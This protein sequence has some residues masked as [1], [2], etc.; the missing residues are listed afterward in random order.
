MKIFN[1]IP[2]WLIPLLLWSQAQGQSDTIDCQAD[3]NYSISNVTFGAGNIG[4]LIDNDRSIQVSIGQPFAGQSGSTAQG[5]TLSNG[6]FGHYD[7]EPQP[8]IAKAS[9]GEFLDRIEVQWEVITDRVGPW[10]TGTETVIYR[11]GREIVTVPLKQKTYVDYNVFP[12]EFYTYEIATSNEYGESYTLP[13]VGF[14]NPNGRVTGKV[15]TRNGSPVADVKVTLSP[16]LGTTL[17]FDGTKSYAYFEN[18]QF[19]FNKYYTVEGWWRNVGVDKE[20]TLFVAND[21]GTTNPVIKISLDNQNRLTYFHDGNADGTGIT[22]VSKDGYNLTSLTREWHHFAAVFDTTKVFLYVDGQRVAET[23]TPVDTASKITQ[24]ELGKNGRRQFSGYY[25]GYL[26]ELRIWDVGRTRSDIRKFNQITLTGE[27]QWLNSYWKF[28]EQFGDKI[29][30]Y[31]SKPVPDRNHGFICSTERSDLLS[32]AKQGAYTDEGGDYIIKGI[33]YGSGTTFSASPSKETPIGFALSLDGDDDFVS[34]HNDRMNLDTAMTL[35]GWFKTAADNKSMVIYEATNSE[36]SDLLLQLKVNNAGQLVVVSGI[37]GALDSIQT[38]KS[39]ND[40][41]WYHYAI[42]HDGTE[43]KLYIDSEEVGSKA[44]S[45]SQPY[46]SRYVIGR[47]QPDTSLTGSSYFEGLID[48]TRIWRYARTADQVSGTMEQILEGD[49]KGI[50]DPEGKRGVEV[51]WM[52]GEGTGVTITDATPNGHVGVLVNEQ[53]IKLSDTDSIVANWDGDDIPLDV[54]YFVHDFD[55]NARNVSL[56]PSNVAVDRVDFT[57]ISQLGVSGFVKYANTDCFAEGIELLINGSSL[58][59][60]VF[61]D[62]SGKFIVELEPG[63]INAFLSTSSEGLDFDPAFIELPRMIRPLAGQK[64]DVTTTRKLFGKVAG[65][66]C[67]Y[68]IGGASVTISSADEC[69]TK[70]VEVDTATAEFLFENIP[71]LE[72]TISVNHVDPIIQ[73]SF[74]LE[75]A[76]SVNLQDEDDSINFIYYSPIRAE[77]E[78]VNTEDN[79]CGYVLM[80]QNKEYTARVKAYQLYNGQECLLDG[81]RVYFDDRIGAFTPK[82]TVEITNGF[83]DYVTTVGVPNI[84][85][86]YT[87]NMTV[88]VEGRNGETITDFRE[89]IVLGFRT[90]RNSTFE[91]STPEMPFF[92]LRDPPGDA[93]YSF[94]EK[95]QTVC[96]NMSMSYSTS[97]STGFSREVSLGTDIE[98]SVGLGFQKKTKIDLTLDIGFEVAST[99]SEGEVKEQEMCLTTNETFSTSPGELETG[100]SGGDVYVG[101]AFNMLVGVNKRLNFDSATCSFEVIDDLMMNPRGFSTTY[102]Y[103]QGY[104]EQILIPGFEK[105]GKIN[106]ANQWR[107]VL[108][109][110]SALEA[111]ATNPENFSF[112]SGVAF[113]RAR[114]S[115][116][117]SSQMFTFGSEFAA[118]VSL[119]TG[120]EVD[121]VGNSIG[122]SS[123]VNVGS[124]GSRGISQNTTKTVGYVLDDEDFGDNYT[125]DIKT[126]ALGMPVFDLLGGES[127]CPWEKGTLLRMAVELTPTSPTTVVNVP[128]D[129]AASFTFSL[130]N[131]SET[132]DDQFY[133]IRVLQEFNPNGAIIKINGVPVEN[134]ISIW[135]P[136]AQNVDLTV[137]VEKGPDEYEYNGLVIE[138]YAPC[139]LEKAKE[140][141]LS[142]ESLIEDSETTNF[143]DRE[144][145][146]VEFVKTC[147]DVNLFAPDQNWLINSNTGDTLAIT[148]NQFD[149]TMAELESIQLQY[150]PIVEGAPFVTIDTFTRASFTDNFFTYQWDV[151]SIHDNSYEIRAVSFCNSGFAPKASGMI[152]GKMDREAPVVFGTPTPASILK[153]EG[154]ISVEFEEDIACNEIISL[155]IPADLT[156]GA[157]NNV[158][159]TNTVTGLAIEKNVTCID[160]KLIIIPDIQN[161]FIE[162]Q[163]LRVDLLGIED[164]FGNQQTTPVTWEFNVNRN[165]ITWIDDD[166]ITVVQEGEAT[167]F[168]KRFSNNGAFDVNFNLSGPLDVATL[169]ETSLPAW[170]SATPLSGTITSGGNLPVEFTVSDQLSGGSYIN[171]AVVATSFGSDALNLNVRVLCEEPNWSVKPADFQNSMTI[172]ADLIVDGLGS[173]DVYDR[174]AALVDGE[175]RGV[176]KVEYAPE[177]DKHQVYLTVFSNRNQGELIRYEVWDAS[178]CQLLGDVLQVDTFKTNAVLGIPTNPH[179]IEATKRIVQEVPLEK[180][181]NW[182]S[183]NLDFAD[184]KLSSVLK[185]LT[186]VRRDIFKDQ[187]RFAQYSTSLGWVGPLDTVNNLSMYQVKLAQA[188]TLVNIGNPV[189][190]ETT[191]IPVRLGWNWISYLP[192]ASQDVNRALRG[193]TATTGDLIKNQYSFAQYIEGLGWIGSLNFMVPKEGYLFRSQTNGLLEYPFPPSNG[194]FLEEEEGMS[195]HEELGIDINQYEYSMSATAIVSD[196]QGMLTNG[197]IKVYRG[198]NL[199]GYGKGVEVVGLGQYQFFISVFGDEKGEINGDLLK[200]DIGG[201]EYSISERMTFTPNQVIGT[202]IDPLPLHVESVVNGYHANFSHGLNAIPNPFEGTT[203]VSFTLPIGTEARLEVVNLLG[204]EVQTLFNGMVSDVITTKTWNGQSRNGIIQPAGMYL[205]RLITDDSTESIRIILK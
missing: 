80:R 13:V 105:A 144:I 128:E 168:V 193:L 185:P 155:G 107:K 188:D 132:G 42:T 10:I 109:F 102:L 70:T 104:V 124:E 194:R 182:M 187:S 205:V 137:T 129:K 93:S 34:F 120:I 87:K 169:N 148:V 203:Q 186:P 5:V 126:D 149:T 91:T 58:V 44:D 183:F 65:G 118:E 79:N 72:Y 99:T 125:L 71:P 116:M 96:N 146:N 184:N 64:Y 192:Q 59:P 53:Y 176:G 111:T 157:R 17:R 88:T 6:F 20:Q 122:V 30:D 7:Q 204:Q 117:T 48:E 190:I 50:V 127:L 170:L 174:V 158:A 92:V 36:T 110:D 180:G 123:G 46:I 86:P 171:K 47:S 62:A 202:P 97:T 150:R 191:R 101:G 54:E 199:V 131:I 143:F 82:D 84:A 130:A 1:K 152:S 200:L 89:A 21:S 41:F 112:S 136:Y 153:P 77:L 29:F 49:E 73:A 100:P 22:L 39:Y 160:N 145:I 35:E 75:G 196:P 201:S 138:M 114:T 113:E 198:D 147:S 195:L 51:N 9:E 27:E 26:D 45:W 33:F 69:F 189:D 181:W 68:P 60:P 14:L 166:I 172:T 66:T 134:G 43:I 94:L 161:K 83:A 8:P 108:S 162:G 11:N 28:D 16:D 15:E 197:L 76:K 175:V 167:T 90:A 151:S 154:Q 24:F 165:P 56:D 164:L 156:P 61:S 18:E 55:P 177:I 179:E 133:A 106:E 173:T 37:S 63:T 115:E 74:D 57:D 67:E 85:A 140:L 25:E 38:I 163:V 142:I 135:S 4:Y 103:T 95:G 19:E 119:E 52:F 3:I 23:M 81:G 159:L 32:P 31:A 40:E 178:T 78:F 139:E 12:G 141:G 2:A 98:F 121:G